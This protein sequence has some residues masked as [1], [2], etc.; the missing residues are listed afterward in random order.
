MMEGLQVWQE[1][2]G[3][4][5]TNFTHSAQPTIWRLALFLADALEDVQIEGKVF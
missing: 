4:T 2:R 5:N 1:T 3:M